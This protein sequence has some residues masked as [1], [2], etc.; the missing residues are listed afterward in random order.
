MTND[1][2]KVFTVK[3]ARKLCDLGFII[4]GTVH[5]VQ[6]PWLNV[7]LFEDSQDLRDAVQKYTGISSLLEDDCHGRQ[8]K[9]S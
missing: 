1:T 3:L 5:N 8:K 2:Y 6:K 9:K 7:Y 4:V